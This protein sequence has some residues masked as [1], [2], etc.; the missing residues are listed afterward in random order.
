MAFTLQSAMD[1]ARI[2][3]NDADK[4]RYPDAQL[5]TWTNH[6]LVTLASRRPDLFIGQYNALPTGEALASV[7]F[8]IP[9]AYLS[10]IANY[11]T[12]MAE[13]VDDENANSG[14]AA[15][16]LQLIGAEVPA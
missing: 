9:A 10:V 13:M 8:P 3:L 4:V 16:F 2:P 11:V 6:A 15:A 7:A 1:L 5:L 14:R 12:A